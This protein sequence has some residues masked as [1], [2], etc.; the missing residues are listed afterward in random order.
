MKRTIRA[1]L[2]CG[3]LVIAT[4]VAWGQSAW[5][6]RPVRMIVPAPAGSAPDMFARLY[7]EQLRLSLGQAVVI[8]NRPGAS[9][10]LA[11]DAVAKAAPDGYT[12][13]YGYN[14]PFTMNPHLFSKM[15]YDALKDLV[16]VTQTLTTAY[17][18]VANNDFAPKNLAELIA[19]AKRAPGTIN[20]G[21]Y[22]PGTPG[23][24]LMELLDERTGAK[25]VQVPYKQT[26][27]LDVI[28]G[29]VSFSIEPFASAIPY[30]KSGKL[31]GL[32]V[33]SPKR[34]ETLP[35]VPAMSETVQGMEL[36][37]WNAVWVPAGTPQEVIAKLNNEFVR[38]TN[39]PQM[40]RR[41]AEADST[42]TGTTPEAITQIIR[43]EFDEW[44]KLIKAK[45]IRID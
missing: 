14:Q 2:A 21:T 13:L 45:S 22:G 7:G 4:T 15:P 31:R 40:R 18:I 39:S 3:G 5:P 38:I 28:G 25:M 19:A 42:P 23:H 8:E 29:V 26:P 33:A 44:G 32:A 20:Y 16:P 10:M 34:I 43:K 30:V 35:D 36:V 17:V 37:G 9:G 41:M 11:G 27:I 1:L 12:V 24:L 6:I